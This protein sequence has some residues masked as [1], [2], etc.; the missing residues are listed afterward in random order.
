MTNYN[1]EMLTFIHEL[2]RNEVVSLLCKR[3]RASDAEYVKIINLLKKASELLD[4]KK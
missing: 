2:L 4:D 3:G 1:V